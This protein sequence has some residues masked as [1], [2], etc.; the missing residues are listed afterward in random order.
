VQVLMTLGADLKS[1]DIRGRTPLAAGREAPECGEEIIT[2]LRVT[3]GGDEDP[4][5]APPAAT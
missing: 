2:L 3:V 4:T 5:E 1:R